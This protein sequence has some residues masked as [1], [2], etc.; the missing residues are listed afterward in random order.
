[1][2]NKI[3]HKLKNLIIYNALKIKYA[4]VISSFRDGKDRDSKIIT[5]LEKYD[6][7]KFLSKYNIAFWE[8]A[9]EIIINNI[10]FS[11]ARKE[12]I[13]IGFVCNFD[14]TWACDLLYKQLKDNP[15]FEPII[16]VSRFYNGD[17][18]IVEESYIR[19]LKYFKNKG[20]IVK[21]SED[22]LSEYLNSSVFHPNIDLLIYLTP[23]SFALE[24]CFNLSNIPT[25]IMTALIPYGIYVADLKTAQ[26]NL[27]DFSMFLYIYDLP[28]YCEEAK[29][30]SVLGD[31]NRIPSGYC[32]LDPLYAKSI[33]SNYVWK[34]NS[35][36][37]KLIYAPHHSIRNR[38]QRFSTF[39]KNYLTILNLAQSSSENFSW[40]IKPH[41]ILKQACIEEGVFPNDSSYDEYIDKWNS[42]ENGRALIGGDYLDLFISS[43]AIILDSD[44]FL[45]EYL[46]TGK[47]IILLTR[48]TQK[49]SKLGELLYPAFYKIDGT[50]KK[51]LQEL[52]TRL[53][54]GYDPLKT[55]RRRVFREYLDY[56]GIN[57]KL[58]SSFIYEHILEIGGLANNEQKHLH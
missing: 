18:K 21:N 22:F 31:I 56:R 32:K 39:D 26:Y 28:F 45:A 51:G 6:S 11:L 19:T 20:F 16:F 53:R 42:L 55:V 17:L 41:P 23:Y 2:Q 50:N 46:F 15:K 13:R 35:D 49:F 5:K 9:R 33:I 8:K 27:P 29:E 24:K 1:M 10:Q 44:S 12:R 25:S 4:S 57:G 48:D 43:D 47:P 40:V 36:N 38:E 30:K 58:A 14:D 54:K 3:L 52:L 7:L 37:Y 34:G